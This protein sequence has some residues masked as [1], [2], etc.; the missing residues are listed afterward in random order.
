MIIFANRCVSIDGDAD[1]IM[2]FFNDENGL[3]HMLDGDK[4]A[5]LGNFVFQKHLI[6][7]EIRVLCQ[8]S[9]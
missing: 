6:L 5:T 7:L 8:K 4:I 2:Y 3:F 1:R 9:V